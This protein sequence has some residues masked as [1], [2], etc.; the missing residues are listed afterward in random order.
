MQSRTHKAKL[1]MFFSLL[2]Q[3]VAIVCGLIMPR[4]MIEYFG[5]EAYGAVGSISA[6]LA[7]ITLIEGGVGAVTRS[8]LYKAFA[9]KSKDQISAVINETKRLYRKIAIVFILY[10]I[11]IAF[12]FKYISHNTAFSYWYSFG[13]VIVIAFSTFA[14]YFIGISYFLLLQADQSNYI[15]SIFT[16]LSTAFNTACCIILITLKSDLLT[17]KLASSLIFVLKPIILS[18]Y[19]KKRYKLIRTVS[20][21]KL[22]KQKGAAIGQH[23]AWVLHNNTDVTVLTVFKDLTYVSVYSV[24]EMVIGQLKNVINSFTSGMEAVFGNMYANGERENL[25]K[26]FGYYE[27]LLSLISVSFFSTATVLIIP[28]V[29]LYTAGITDV[30]YIYPGFSIMLMAA[31]LLYC[32]RT[33]YGNMV[34]AAGHFK[35]TQVAAYGEATINI[36]VSIVLVIRYGLIGVAIGTVAATLFRFVYYVWYLSCNIMFRPIKL[37]LKRSAVNS[38]TCILI[39]AFGNLII[40][41]LT[42]DN[43]LI[44][45]TAGISVFLVSGV[46]TL[47]TNI[48][49]YKTDVLEIIHRGFGKRINNGKKDKVN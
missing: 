6:F 35:Q 17:V 49:M 34:V 4:L 5:S 46:I 22:L 39:F 29:R 13:L 24:Y 30:E 26:T 41:Q 19:V 33:P 28:F 25:Q 36:I 27:T 15:L 38:A 9:M 11:I 37:W 32:L 44:W 42:I 14:E 21:E 31:S 18:I 45:I 40:N 43:Y 47:I 12:L 1:N 7:Y 20:K 10:V 3:G 48:V 23:I 16:M 8:A 2:Q